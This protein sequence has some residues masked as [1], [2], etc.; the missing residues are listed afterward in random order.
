MIWRSLASNALTIF[1]VI[2]FLIGGVILWGNDQFR[3]EGPLETAI[4]FKVDPGSSMRPVVENLETAG[5]ISSRA[6]FEIGVQYTEQA[7][8]LKAGAFRVPAGASM[9]EILTIIT[10]GGASTCGTEI[11]YRI[12]VTRNLVQV[13]EIDPA[14]GRFALISSY[15]PGDE[16]PTAIYQARKEQNDTRF[17]LAI[18]EGVTS[19]QVVTSLR[20]LD[21]LSGAVSRLPAEGSLAP[22][23]YELTKGE[24]RA[25]VIQRMQDAQN[26]VLAS[27]WQTRDDRLPI[28][29]MEEALILASIIEKE[30]G[31]AEEREQVA[32][33]FINRLRQGMK[34]QT[35][36]TVIYGITKGQ[37]TLGRGL[38]R[39]EL[40]RPTDWNTYVITGLPPTPIANPGRAAIRA[41]VNPD[42]T[43]Y[44]F[45]V[46]D[47]TGGHAFA[48]N[49]RDHNRNVAR[50]RE[51]EAGQS[52]N[53]Q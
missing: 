13:R 45:F 33:V 53:D 1:I 26:R 27:A 4:C 42:T 24:D 5:A 2:F 48:T 39:S 32:S 19:W 40:R 29:T 38:R 36:P 10:E 9:A 22:D 15:R 37:G 20:D 34:L 12:G 35:D 46:A 28:A 41:A 52:T 11:V 17:R 49:L 6:I 43:D 44:L 3:G 31:R 50:W 7:G 21:I 51:I 47:G 18:A 25:V 8:N 23:S 16:E 30:T 14:T